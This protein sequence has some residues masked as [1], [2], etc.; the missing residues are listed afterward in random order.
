MFGGMKGLETLPSSHAYPD[1]VFEEFGVFE[2][3]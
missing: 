2:G 3:F 1:I